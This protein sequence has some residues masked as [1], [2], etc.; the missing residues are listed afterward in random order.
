MPD[1]V[2]LRAPR[3]SDAEALTT[4]MNLPIVQ[5]GTARTPFTS[6]AW[7]EA[8]INKDDP[9]IHSVVAE[10]DGTALGWATLVRRI[11][12]HAHGGDLSIVVHDAYA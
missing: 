1:A 6:Q 10:A 12:R 8:R 9:R 11:G 4:L 5:P 7:V 3:Q 2:L